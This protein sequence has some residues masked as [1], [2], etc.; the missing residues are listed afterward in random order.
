MSRNNRHVV[1]R[2][3]DWAVQRE[4]GDRASGIYGTQR[5]AEDAAR[6]MTHNSGGGEVVTHRPDGRIRDSD[7]IDPAK[8]PFPPRG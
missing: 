3:D 1:P 6:R 5:E 8:D 4:G 2:G 7:T